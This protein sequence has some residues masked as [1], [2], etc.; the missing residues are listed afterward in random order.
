MFPNGNIVNTRMEIF[1][2]DHETVGDRLRQVRGDMNQDAFAKLLD[3]G[4]TTLIRY[5]K[6]ERSPDADLI[7]RLWVLFK[8]DALWLLTGIGARTSGEQLSATEAALI[9]D[10][11]LCPEEA[12]EVLLRTASLLVKKN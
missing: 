2:S 3:I 7:A 1:M 11:R 10:F 9:S 4:R 6:G 8:V 12:K 5:E